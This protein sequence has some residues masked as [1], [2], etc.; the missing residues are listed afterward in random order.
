VRRDTGTHE[1]D[2]AKQDKAL[3]RLGL[4]CVTGSI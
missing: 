4:I 3:A 1:H 2:L